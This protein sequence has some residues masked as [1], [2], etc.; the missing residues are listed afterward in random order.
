M[1][2]RHIVTEIIEKKNYKLSL[3]RGNNHINEK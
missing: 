3:K 2:L 1:T